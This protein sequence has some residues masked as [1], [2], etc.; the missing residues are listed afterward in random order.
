MCLNNYLTKQLCYFVNSFKVKHFVNNCTN[1]DVI[2]VVVN[3]LYK[4]F[5]RLMI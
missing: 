1:E 3:L 5:L 4:L 2:K